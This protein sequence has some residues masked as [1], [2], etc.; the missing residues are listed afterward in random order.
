V[1]L[2]LVGDSAAAGVGAAS[3]DEALSGRLVDQL[4]PRF[5]VSWM[6]VARIGATTAGTARHLARRPAKEC[7]VFDVA[8]LSV[9]GNDV[10][11]RRPLD[12]WLEDVSEVA[13]LLRMRFAVR[14]IL[15]SGLP[16]MHAFTALPQPL[17]WYLGATA[18]KFDR[19]LAGWGKAQPDCEHVPLEL[20]RSA[21]RLATDGLHPGPQLYHEW[22]VELARCIQA[23]WAKSP[24]PDFR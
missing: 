24:A 1:R 17:R 12:Q 3:L 6:L 20:I 22:S 8:V 4:V 2:L 10:M 16:P 13:S 7:G 19:A 11:R 5:R 21:D 18:R 14:Y 9:G 23:R 15:F